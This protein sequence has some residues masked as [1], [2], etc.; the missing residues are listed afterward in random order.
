LPFFSI[1]SNQT[2][3]QKPIHF[4]VHQINTHL[5][6]HEPSKEPVEQGGIREVEI[7]RRSKERENPLKRWKLEEGRKEKVFQAVKDYPIK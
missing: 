6:Q 4:L 3:Q 5:F 2:K 7:K 1:L